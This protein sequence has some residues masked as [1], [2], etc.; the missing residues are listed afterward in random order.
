MHRLTLLFIFLSS[1]SF[2]RPHSQRIDSS[3]TNIPTSYTS[4]STSKMTNL[5]GI[6]NPQTI[7]IDN[8]SATEVAVNCS[9]ATNTV[10][11]DTSANNIYVNATN[12]ACI[13]NAQLNADCYI[14]SM[15]S[16]ISSGI[17]VVTVTARE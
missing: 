16:A 5:T 11:S 8:R 6:R 3:S 7:C 14:R 15:G 17:V 10:P 2:A 4:A 1:L 13:D 9:V 12:A